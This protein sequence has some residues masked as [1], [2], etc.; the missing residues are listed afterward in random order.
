MLDTRQEWLMM[1]THPWALRAALLG[2]SHQEGNREQTLSIRDNWQQG[3]SADTAIISFIF[4]FPNCTMCDCHRGDHLLL[5][6]DL[7]KPLNFFLLSFGQPD[8]KQKQLKHGRRSGGWIWKSGQSQLCKGDGREGGQVYLWDEGYFPPRFAWSFKPH[9]VS[10]LFP[11]RAVV[12][13]GQVQMKTLLA[14]LPLSHASEAFI[15]CQFLLTSA[16]KC[17]NAAFILCELARFKLFL[18]G[19]G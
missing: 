18:A 13:A 5:Y 11:G 12:S 15:L 8:V 4:L 2:L 1:L 14:E 9:L 3:P 10:M 16:W 19:R 17:Q 7:R 6:C